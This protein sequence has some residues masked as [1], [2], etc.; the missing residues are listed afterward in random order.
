MPAADLDL[1]LTRNGT[2]IFK[3]QIA[4]LLQKTGFAEGRHVGLAWGQWLGAGCWVLGAGCF[5]E[6]R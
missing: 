5:G 6:E 3:N 1:R 2:G 4:Q